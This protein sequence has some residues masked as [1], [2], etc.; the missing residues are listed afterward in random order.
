M[1][2]QLIP[3]YYWRTVCKIGQG[4]DCCRYLA[5]GSKGL[6]CLKHTELQPELD[7][8]AMLKTMHAQADNCPGY[9]VVMEEDNGNR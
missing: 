3:E 7:K 8:R 1:K 2:E 6:E 5:C 4:A 9:G